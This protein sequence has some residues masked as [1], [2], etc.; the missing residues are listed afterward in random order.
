MYA[1]FNRQLAKRRPEPGPD[2]SEI[3]KWLAEDLT[4]FEGYNEFYR[5]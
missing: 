5:A 2:A 4:G 3:E 1:E